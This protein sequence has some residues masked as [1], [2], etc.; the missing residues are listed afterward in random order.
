[1]TKQRPVFIIG[2]DSNKIA[3]DFAITAWE[4]AGFEP[5]VISGSDKICL[6]PRKIREDLILAKTTKDTPIYILAHGI[7]KDEK[8]YIALDKFYPTELIVSELKKYGFFQILSCQSGYAK[9]REA[10]GENTPLITHSGAKYPTTHLTSSEAIASHAKFCQQMTQKHGR[11]P[12]AYEYF[13]FSILT[14]PETNILSQVVNRKVES[15]KGSA[16]R[17]PSD[18]KSIENYLEEQINRFRGEFRKGVLG[19][20]DID[21]IDMKEILPEGFLNRYLELATIVESS[22][23]DPKKLEKHIGYVKAYLDTGIIPNFSFCG[24]VI[25][26]LQIACQVGNKGLVELLLKNGAQI[27]RINTCDGKSP[28]YITCE[29][30]YVDIAKLLVRNKDTNID[31]KQADGTTPIYIASQRGHTKIVK[32]LLK[33]E[34]DI[35]GGLYNVINPLMIAALCGKKETVDLLLE[36]I[37]AP[38]F[39]EKK[40]ASRTAEDFCITNNIIMNPAHNKILEKSASRLATMGNHI[41]IAK[42]IDSRLLELKKAYRHQILTMTCTLKRPNPVL[43]HP[44][45]PKFKIAKTENTGRTI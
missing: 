38:E 32:L 33:N 4:K 2:P 22:R 6:T 11:M 12:N 21:F 7:V 27:N 35:N 14:S 40:S 24:G 25:T 9:S 17:K 13:E 28:F 43:Q 10:A 18:V 15:F 42:K 36:H 3:T 44:K 16:P 19:H 5:V 26:A 31:E 23:K 34:A 8:H 30:G 37:K 41:E 39:L 45:E 20:K 1:M 29:Q